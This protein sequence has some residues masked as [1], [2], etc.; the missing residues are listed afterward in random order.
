M[1]QPSVEEAS[2]ALQRALLKVI[3]LGQAVPHTAAGHELILSVIRETLEPFNQ[4][5]AG[6]R[7]VARCP[8][9]NW[10]DPIEAK[11]ATERRVRGKA[12]PIYLVWEEE[13]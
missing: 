9:V 2:D 5:F 11:A 7:L 1:T 4:R 3:D 13:A 8:P 10:D 12:D 6:G